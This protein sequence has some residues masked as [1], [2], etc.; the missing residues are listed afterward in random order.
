VFNPSIIHTFEKIYFTKHQNFVVF[1][2]TIYPL[3][4]GVPTLKRSIFVQPNR[5]ICIFG[6]QSLTIIPLW[7][8]SYAVFLLITAIVLCA[9]SSLMI[10]AAYAIAINGEQTINHRPASWNVIALCLRYFSLGV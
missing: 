8:V 6:R 2:A 5:L 10:S 9:Q 3:S 7:F 4:C 1:T